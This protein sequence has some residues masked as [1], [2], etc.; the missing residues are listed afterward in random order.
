MG[1]LVFA[2][3]AFGVYFAWLKLRYEP[4]FD[5]NDGKLDPE[6][7]LEPA[8]VGAWFLPLAIFAFGWTSTASI[9]WMAPVIASGLFS[10]GTF[11]IFS[12]GLNYLA[13]AY[14]LYIASTFAANDAFRGCIGAALPLVA[15]AIFNNLQ[16]NGPSAFPVAW[17]CTLI[18]CISLLLAPIPILLHIYGARLRKMSKYATTPGESAPVV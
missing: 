18:G 15:R 17:G 1:I 10:F 6:I 7:W 14:P 3:L 9:H 8:I 16:A 13:D 11:S 4:R 12:S 5:A 2:F